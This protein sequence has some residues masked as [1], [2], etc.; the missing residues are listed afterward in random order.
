MNGGGLFETGAGSSSPKHVQQL[1]G[2]GHLR[3]DSL[4][5]SSRFRRPQP[6]RAEPYSG[7]Q[8]GT[9]PESGWSSVR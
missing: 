8:T 7:L 5:S 1:L 4:A 3:W 2:K 9:P 6:A